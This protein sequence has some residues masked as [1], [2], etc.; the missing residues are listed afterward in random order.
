MVL[1]EIVERRE[2]VSAPPGDVVL[3][4]RAYLASAR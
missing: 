1:P 2:D 3:F 4:A